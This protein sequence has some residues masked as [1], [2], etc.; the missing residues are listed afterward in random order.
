MRC[1]HPNYVIDL[2]FNPE[3]GKKKLKFVGFRPDLSSFQ[4]LTARYGKESI[5][6]LPCGKCLPCRLNHAKEW[7]VRCV[8]ESLQYE[9]NYFLTLTY[10]DSHLPDD[11]LLR[12]SDVQ[13]FLKRFRSHFGQVRYFGCGEYGS[14]NARPHYH[15]ILFGANIDDLRNIGSGLYESKTLK[16]LWPFGF[17]Y[18]GFV[19]YASCNYVAKYSTKKLFNGRSDEFLMCSTRP[20][21]GYQ[22]CKDN[23]GDIFE[24]GQV[25]GP[26]GSQKSATLP[27]YFEKMAEA[28]DKS[29]FIK[30][31]EQRLDSSAALNI[32]ELLKH[33]IENVEELLSYKEDI[34]KSD[35]AHNRGGYRK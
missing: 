7:A 17:H 25:F 15:L 1:A 35:F 26:F 4:Q 2:G 21:I 31:K 5:I 8:L 13:K 29:K 6:P 10:D 34:L 22:W 33:S 3:N 12:R 14:K 19:S 24:Y 32:N 9:N 18:I 23:L 28:L 27:R 20:G 11:G 16:E 30:L